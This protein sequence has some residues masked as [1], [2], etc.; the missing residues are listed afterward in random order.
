MALSEAMS[1]G[2]PA[3]GLKMCNGVNSL[4]KDGVNGY[5]TEASPEAFREALERLMKDAALR[6][7]MGNA[8]VEAMKAY[9]PEI[10]WDLWEH[11]LGIVA[12]K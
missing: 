5:L 10:I 2:L 1:A 9:A 8:G 3:V 12:V 11:A 4:I 6:A 7:Q